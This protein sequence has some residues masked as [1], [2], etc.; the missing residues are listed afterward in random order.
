M[1]SLPVPKGHKTMLFS[2]TMPG[3]IKQ[4][5]QNYLHKNAVEVRANMETVN[6]GVITNI[7]W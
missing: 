1:K 3:T 4:L 6:Q 2:A 5:V 7:L